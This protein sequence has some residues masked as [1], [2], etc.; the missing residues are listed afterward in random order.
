M[1]A[2]VHSALEG[3]AHATLL[4][5]CGEA[6]LRAWLQE[7]QHHTDHLMSK[8]GQ[9]ALAWDDLQA[10]VQTAEDAS[11]DVISAHTPPPPHRHPPC[12]PS[13]ARRMAC[14]L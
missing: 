14:I 2:C 4:D 3:W 1:A 9:F 8:A 10:G 5:S 13:H 11:E 12:R 7:C 6:R